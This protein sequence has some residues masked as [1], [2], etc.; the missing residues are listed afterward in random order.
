MWEYEEAKAEHSNRNVQGLTHQD[1]ELS[2][3]TGDNIC[4]SEKSASDM[5]IPLCADNMEVSATHGVTFQTVCLCA[6]KE[7]E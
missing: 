2:Y 5:L 4:I 1:T 3:K 6:P 7:P